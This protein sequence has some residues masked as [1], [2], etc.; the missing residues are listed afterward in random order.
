MSAPIENGEPPL[1]ARRMQ[2]K[3]AYNF[4]G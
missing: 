3:L 4:Q 1:H 2:S